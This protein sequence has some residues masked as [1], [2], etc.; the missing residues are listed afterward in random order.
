M[1]TEQPQLTPHH[2]IKANMEVVLQWEPLS[3][4]LLI[5]S[6]LS[7]SSYPNV[8]S[9]TWASNYGQR[10]CIVVRLVRQLT[11][12]ILL[13]RMKK[14][15]RNIDHSKVRWTSDSDPIFCL[16]P[17]QKFHRL[18]FRNVFEPFA[19]QPPPLPQALIREKLS[20]DDNEIATTS[21][22]VSLLC[23]LSKARIQIPCRPTTCNHLQCFDASTFLQVYKAYYIIFIW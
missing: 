6:P 10:H 16:K 21:L 13:D 14:H 9:V 15:V 22:R 4:L 7:P 2:P 1:D 11:S 23:P 17:D 5:S 12:Q 20:C 18:T 19:F 8:L 3:L